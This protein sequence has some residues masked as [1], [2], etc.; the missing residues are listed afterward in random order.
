MRWVIELYHDVQSHHRCKAM[1]VTHRRLPPPKLR[2]KASISSSSQMFRYNL[3]NLH[4]RVDFRSNASTQPT[5]S[6]PQRLSQK[7]PLQCNHLSTLLKAAVCSFPCSPSWLISASSVMHC[8]VTWRI[9]AL[10]VSYC[11]SPLLCTCKWT[12]TLVSF[13]AHFCSTERMFATQWA[14]FC[15]FAEW[16]EIWLSS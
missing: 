7:S 10:F 1:Q 11:P 16:L 15:I 2:A 5:Q 14:K 8:S 3:I 4:D 12:G 6:R 9:N 13:F